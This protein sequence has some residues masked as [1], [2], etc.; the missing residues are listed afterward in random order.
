[1]ARQP[2]RVLQRAP[3]ADGA[4]ARISPRRYDELR[5]AILLAVPKDAE[6]IALPALTRAVSAR[7][8][9]ELFRDVSLRWYMTAVKL[10]LE[11]QGLIERTPGRRPQRVR[12]VQKNRPRP[13]RPRPARARRE[14]PMD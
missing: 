8:P 9:R 6:G 2:K 7:V 11:A 12:R 3:N 1:M 10:D 5:R 4:G 14:Q 13:T